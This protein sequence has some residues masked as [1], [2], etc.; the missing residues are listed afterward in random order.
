MAAR[1]AE[2]ELKL[3]SRDSIQ[4]SLM[5]G[6]EDQTAWSIPVDSK[7]IHYQEGGVMK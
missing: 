7:N 6:R 3:S 1:A 4:V 5:G 2:P